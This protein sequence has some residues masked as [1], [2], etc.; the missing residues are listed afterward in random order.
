L[1]WIIDCVAADHPVE[2]VTAF[3]ADAADLD[4][5]L[6]MLRAQVPD[7]EVVVA[8]MGPV[9]GTHLGPGCIGATYFR[10]AVPA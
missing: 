10:T 1:A 6:E 5:F 9:I 3:H 4:V 2:S 8:L 7:Q